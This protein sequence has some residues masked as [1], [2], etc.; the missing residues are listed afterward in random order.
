MKKAGADLYCFHYEA[1]FSSDSDNPEVQSDK[2]TNPRALTRFIH[3]Q[4]LLAGIALKPATSVDVVWELLE[5][6][7]PL[8]R[9][10]VSSPTF[11]FR[12]FFEPRPP[13]V[14]HGVSKDEH[15][16]DIRRHRWSLL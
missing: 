16:A 3:E 14:E 6:E 13:V 1:A 9:P 15:N 7:D 2:K 11:L 8:E 5:S 10:D 4:G 12:F